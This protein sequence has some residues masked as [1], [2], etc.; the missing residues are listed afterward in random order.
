MQ[1]PRC[2]ACV[3]YPVPRGRGLVCVTGRA[4]EKEEKKKHGPRVS[5]IARR[6]RPLG[7]A[8]ERWAGIPSWQL[9][10]H[11]VTLAGRAEL[12]GSRCEA[13]E[14]VNE[15]AGFCSRAIGPS[16]SHAFPPPAAKAAGTRHSPGICCN[17]LR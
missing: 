12:P 14:C 11:A 3:D 5:D 17:V 6:V 9:G 13:S 7:E 2:A 4:G 1:R 16:A 15:R 8:E 10:L